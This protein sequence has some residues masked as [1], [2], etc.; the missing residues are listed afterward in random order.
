VYVYVFCDVTP[1]FLVDFLRTFRGKLLYSSD[2]TTSKL[3]LLYECFSS[4][5]QAMKSFSY[6]YQDI[7]LIQQFVKSLKH[8]INLNNLKNSV[9]TSQENTMCIRCEDQYVIIFSEILLFTVW[10]IWLGQGLDDWGIGVQFP[11]G[12]RDSSLLHSIRRG[13]EPLIQW[14]PVVK[15]PGSILT[16]H[17]LLMPKLSKHGAIPPLPLTCSWRDA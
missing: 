9:P 14:L 12:I 13:S 4:L 2:H 10:I 5:S 8:E 17:L 11:V 6:Q 1:Y 15:W 3:S 16:A 7:H